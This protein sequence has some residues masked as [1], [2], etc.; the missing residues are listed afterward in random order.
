[1][2]RRLS[3][4]RLIEIAAAGAATAG[5]GYA[6]LF[7]P[8]DF[9]VERINI[10]AP[11]P[12]GLRIGAVSDFH[13]ADHISQ[14]RVEA[15]VRRLRAEAPDLILLL[16]DYST[17]MH[18]ESV[19]HRNVERALEILGTLEA[20]LGVYA[21]LG[22]HDVTHKLDDIATL[23][24]EHGPTPLI[25]E[26]VVLSTHG[27]R[28]GIVG[29]ADA[30]QMKPK[31]R[32]ALSAIPPGVPYLGL[33][34]E[35]DAGPKMLPDAALV[36]SGHSHGGQVRLPLI[37]APILPELGRRLPWGLRR[38]GKTLV[39]TSRGVGMVPPRIRINCRPEITLITIVNQGGQRP[40]T[41]LT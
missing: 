17:A 20:P 16:G 15:A 30:L 8:S 36:L 41:P 35:P 2:A 27:E 38:D 39:Y 6:L 18:T 13:L 25:D 21:I 26:S 29:L 22:N 31:P 32:S 24:R 12:T 9:V 10:A 23:I 3:R 37:G 7:E 19:I 1:M 14:Q 4:R 28:F 33:V 5:G 40:M 11:L 34:H